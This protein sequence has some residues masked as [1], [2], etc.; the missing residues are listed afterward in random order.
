MRGGRG[1]RIDADGDSEG[2]GVRGGRGGLVEGVGEMDCD[3]GNEIVLLELST[4]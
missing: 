2:E 4:D 3:I 1:G